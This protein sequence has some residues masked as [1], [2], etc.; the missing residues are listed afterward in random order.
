MYRRYGISPVAPDTRANRFISCCQLGRRSATSPACER[1][2]RYE[3]Q[4]PLDGRYT[5][6]PVMSG[7]QPRY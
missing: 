3:P 4:E 7:V 6:R 2:V 1:L 5:F